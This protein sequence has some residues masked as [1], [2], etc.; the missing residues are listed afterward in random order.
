M[1]DEFKDSRESKIKG[2]GAIGQKKMRKNINDR[3]KTF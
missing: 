2:P 3:T 1:V